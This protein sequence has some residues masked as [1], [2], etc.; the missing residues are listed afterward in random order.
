MRI[1]APGTLLLAAAAAACGLS[2]AGLSRQYE[3]EEDMH[4]DGSAIV[5]VNSS[6]AAFNAL[7]GTAIE[8]SLSATMD[9][10]LRVLFETPVSHAARVGRPARRHGRRY[11]HAA[12][13]G[14]RRAAA[15]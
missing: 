13:G 5:H 9:D 14:A 10:G 6:V 11:L 7:H 12:G 3:Y 8:P 4:L 15:A 2:P 1:R